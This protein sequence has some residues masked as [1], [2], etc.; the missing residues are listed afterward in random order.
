MVGQRAG[1]CTGMILGQWKVL[2]NIRV[3]LKS[4]QTGALN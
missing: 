3:A 4:I 1:G 2:Q